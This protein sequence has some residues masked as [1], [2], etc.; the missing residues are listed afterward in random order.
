MAALDTWRDSSHAPGPL[1]GGAP[2]L[3]SRYSRWR[4]AGGLTTE[5]GQT[6]T[7]AD[8]PHIDPRC[9]ESA[10]RRRTGGS[11]SARPISGSFLAKRLVR[12]P[13]LPKIGTRR[14]NRLQSPRAGEIEAVLDEVCPMP[15]GR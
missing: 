8:T 9:R 7:D 12:G 2:P 10:H 1:H 4:S 13:L 3:E 14:A 11:V 6:H 15:G 5:G